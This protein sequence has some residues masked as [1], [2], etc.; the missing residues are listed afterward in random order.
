MQ[1]QLKLFFLFFFCV[2][3][4]LRLQFFVDKCLHF[5]LYLIISYKSVYYLLC[6][7]I[8]VCLFFYIIHYLVK[9]IQNCCKHPHR[10]KNTHYVKRSLQFGLPLCTYKQNHP[11]PKIKTLRKFPK[12]PRIL[13][14]INLNPTILVTQQIYFQNSQTVIQSTYH[15]T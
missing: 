10:Y 4:V 11:L 7:L 8:I 15:V 12:P 2:A 13:Y 9:S 1:N 5:R 3:L 6:R 14:V